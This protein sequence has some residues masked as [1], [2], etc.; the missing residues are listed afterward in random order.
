[1]PGNER[2]FG[3]PV[4]VDDRKGLGLARDGNGF[5][6]GRVDR[7]GPQRRGHTIAKRFS[8]IR[9]FEFHAAA[10]GELMPDR[11]GARAA[12]CHPA[13]EDGCLETAAA[14]I[15]GEDQGLCALMAWHDS[16]PLRG[17]ILTRRWRHRPTQRLSA[18]ERRGLHQSLD[19]HTL[20]QPRIA[21]PA[22]GDVLEKI[23]QAGNVNPDPAHG[24]LGAGKADGR[25]GIALPDVDARPAADSAERLVRGGGVVSL[26]MVR[27]HSVET[28][29]ASRAVDLQPQFV[30]AA[31]GQLCPFDV[32]QSAGFHPRQQHHT[33][34]RIDRNHSRCVVD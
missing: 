17:S 16:R 3:A 24:I 2:H 7:R 23:R 30:L 32:S 13:V 27:V 19:V 4:A 6:A 20:A 31:G 18:A 22:G 28:Q 29:R 11:R 15:D 1:M 33:V 5:E 25:F 10:A 8:C 26:Q 21:R 9:D 34:L 14:E 12:D